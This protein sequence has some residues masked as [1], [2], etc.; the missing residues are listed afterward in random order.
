[1]PPAARREWVW[2]SWWVAGWGWV[3]GPR[4]ALRCFLRGLNRAPDLASKSRLTELF[5]AYLPF[6][7]VWANAAGWVLGE[8]RV[9]S[10]DHRRYEPRE[11]KIQRPMN[12]NAA[13]CD[14]AEFGVEAVR[15]EGRAMEPVPPGGRPAG[16]RGFH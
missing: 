15:L 1:M 13:A 6:W 9:G 3:A 12:W 2:A 7:S 11:V 8:K 16:G 10:G 4:R 14:V 5:T